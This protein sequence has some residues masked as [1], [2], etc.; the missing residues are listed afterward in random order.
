MCGEGWTTQW[1]DLVCELLGAAYSVSTEVKR[2][3][4]SVPRPRVKLSQKTL[5]GADISLQYVLKS[6]CS[7]DNLVHLSCEH[8]CESSKTLAGFVLLLSSL[9]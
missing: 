3:V 7:S 6:D 8:H 4:E 5:P 1:S 2:V 9:I